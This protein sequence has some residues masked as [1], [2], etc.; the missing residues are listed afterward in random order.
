[1]TDHT[2]FFEQL[3]QQQQATLM[4]IYPDWSLAR[5]EGPAVL[6]VPP[7]TA[8]RDFFV[9]DLHGMF[10][11][12]AD[13]LK[14]IGFNAQ[15]DRLFSV[16]DLIN[17]G[18][19][20]LMALDYLA[21]PWFFAVL[22][23][24]DHMALDAKENATAYTVWVD[25]NGGEWV[26]SAD[27]NL[28]RQMQD[29]FRCLP[30]VIEIEQPDGGLVGLVHAEVPIGV[31]WQGFTQRLESER[32][33]IKPQAAILSATWGRERIRTPAAPI[34]G[35]QVVI[36]GHTPVKTPSRVNNVIYID[37]GAYH[38]RKGCLTVATLADLLSA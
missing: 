17:R 29:R 30:Y 21:Q 38:L 3:A 22:G 35:V 14:L 28:F 13:Q 34:E 36:C 27:E 32:Q 33:G 23:N 4:A 31:D 6:R 10:E 37:T 8:G 7:N 19:D 11:L 5:T 12:L 15:T 24:H 25:S 1:M 26:R 20:S 16:G 9:G 18:P 2:A